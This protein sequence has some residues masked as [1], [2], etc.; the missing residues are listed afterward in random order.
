[1][2]KEVGLPDPTTSGPPRTGPP[3]PSRPRHAGNLAFLRKQGKSLLRAYQRNEWTAVLRMASVIPRLRSL[4]LPQKRTDEY[5]NLTDA[6]HVVARELGYMNWA[7]LTR[8]IS[9]EPRTK[10]KP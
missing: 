4:V 5:V 9:T 10:V 8:H 3:R 7:A 2:R 6:R 1:M